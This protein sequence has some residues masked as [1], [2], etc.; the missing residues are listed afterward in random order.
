MSSDIVASRKAP[1]MGGRGWQSMQLALILEGGV[2][3]SKSGMWRHH[4]NPFGRNR[5]LDSCARFRLTMRLAL[6]AGLLVAAGCEDAAPPPPVEVARPAE[7]ATVASSDVLSGLRFPGRVRA[8]QRAQLAFNV[9]GKMV[10]LPVDEGKVLAAGG[11]I[12]R[13]DPAAFELRLAAAQAEFEKALTDYNRVHQIWEQNQAIARAEVDQKRTAMEMARSRYGA[14]RKDLEDTR[15]IAPFSGV[16]T[17]RY[18]ENFQSVKANEPVV[19]LQNI[20]ALEI[21][22]HVPE[23]VVR[24]E[25][26]RLA[27]YAVFD[28]VTERR[29]PVT[30]KALAAEAD[31]Q[32]QTYEVV[33][34]LVRPQDMTVLPGMA[35]EVLPEAARADGESGD[36]LIPLEAVSASPDGTP[37]VWVVDPESSRVSRRLIEVGEVHGSSVLVADGLQAGDRIVTA[38]VDH[39]RDGMLVRPL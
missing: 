32:T 21:V 5:M 28:G 25:P 27:A 14:A 20:D 31:P 6:L 16:V 30:L 11:L 19:S 23:R 37:T 7:I 4:A 33:L 18:V 17:R 3:V 34:D 13:L 9:P 29:L 1:K 10:E 12:A 35:V 8:V 15:L 22:I 38:G 26:R 39:L 2:G 24:S 36:L